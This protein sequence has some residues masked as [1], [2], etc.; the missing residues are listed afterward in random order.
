MDQHFK[1]NVPAPKQN[2]FTS[3]ADVH[4]TFQIRVQFLLVELNNLSMLSMSILKLF[5]STCLSSNASPSKARRKIKPYFKLNYFS[6]P[7]NI[8]TLFPKKMLH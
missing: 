6:N 2:L 5:W 4:R 1:E 7:I 3:V 8:F